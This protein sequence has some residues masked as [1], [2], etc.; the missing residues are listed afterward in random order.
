MIEEKLESLIESYAFEI[1]EETKKILKN[2][3]TH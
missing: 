3:K 1:E 2:T